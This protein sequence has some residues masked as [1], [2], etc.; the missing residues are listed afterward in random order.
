MSLLV[1]VGESHF[2]RGLDALLVELDELQMESLLDAVK[3]LEA[4][5]LRRKGERGGEERTH[6]HHQQSFNV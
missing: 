6:V 2:L 3:A 5:G 1:A 4:K